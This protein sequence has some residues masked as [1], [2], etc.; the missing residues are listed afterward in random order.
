M[1]YRNC[2]ISIGEAGGTAARGSKTYKTSL[3][4]S[5]IKAMGLDENNK[6]VEISFDGKRITI[7]KYTTTEEFISEKIKLNHTIEKISFFNNTTLCTVIYA[8]F[9]DRTLRAKNFTDNIIKT[10]F[11]N[12]KSPKWE[13]FQNF[14]FERCIPKERAGI[15]EYLE[16]IDVSEYNPIEI[17][18]R[19]AG[20]MAEDAQWIRMETIR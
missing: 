3:P 12:N 13:D 8:D 19:T 18:K 14:L 11:G 6:D 9:T 5:W 7:E 16:A 2:K 15:R 17:I 10:A 1:E 20:R 4:S